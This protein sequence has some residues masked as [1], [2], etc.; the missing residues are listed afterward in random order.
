MKRASLETRLVL[1]QLILAGA[2]IAIFALSAIALSTRTLEREDQQTL[3]GAAKQFATALEGEWA[4]ESDLAGAARAALDEDAPIG[5][6]V[7]VLDEQRRVVG[8]S[9]PLDAPANRIRQTSIHL[10]RGAWVVVTMSTEPS[11]RSIAALATALALAA[12]P[13]LLLTLL[14]SRAIARGALAPLSRMTAEADRASRDAEIRTLGGASDPREVAQLTDAFDRLLGRLHEL[15]QAERH[16]TEDAAHELR[17]PLT[18]ISG[19]LERAASDS[20]LSESV[21][22]SLRAAREQ[23]RDMSALVEALLLLRRAERARGDLSSV[24]PAVNL[25][26]LAREAVEETRARA[27]EAP[28]IGV[29]A[30][31][32]VLAGGDAQLLSAAIRNLLSNAIKATAAR[33][34]VRVSVFARDGDSVV[35]VDDGG[36]GVRAEDRERIFDPFYRSAEAR[37]EQS[38]F[39]LGL[40]LL[41]RVARAHGGDV[42]V[43]DSALGGARFELR[44]P[45]WSPQAR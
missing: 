13:L 43:E 7:D 23:T 26:D 27:P 4:E 11:R 39:G 20:G 18:V 33:G 44:V 19:E 15:I 14:F 12:I 29:E 3:D 17:T 41:R 42:R 25:A 45:A 38:G 37:A 34:P 10:P 16:F 36:R 32:E 21:R 1:L 24:A 9:A 40:P 2:V 28:D 35:T 30:R 22:A 31:D 6:H 5:V 8:A